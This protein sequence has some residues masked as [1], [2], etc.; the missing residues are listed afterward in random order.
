V[1]VLLLMP[2]C[3]RMVASGTT[4]TIAASKANMQGRKAGR[5]MAGG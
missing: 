4:D 3:L 1:A 2:T 5:P